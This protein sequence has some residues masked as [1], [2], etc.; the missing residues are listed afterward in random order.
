MNL[1][2]NK[3]HSYDNVQIMEFLIFLPTLMNLVHMI[4]LIQ[5]DLDYNIIN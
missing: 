5:K 1:L 4:Y 3:L 2:G